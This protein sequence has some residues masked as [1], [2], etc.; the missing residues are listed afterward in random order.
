[1]SA[2]YKPSDGSIAKGRFNSHEEFYRLSGPNN[3]L[4]ALGLPGKTG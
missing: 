2:S 3:T 4:G 1:M